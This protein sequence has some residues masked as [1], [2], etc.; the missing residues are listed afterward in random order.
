MCIRTCQACVT[1]APPRPFAQVRIGFQLFPADRSAMWWW[2]TSMDFI[3]CADVV[4]NF[5][6]AYR[7]ADGNLEG[8]PAGGGSTAPALYP[9]QTVAQCRQSRSTVARSTVVASKR[10]RSRLTAANCCCTGI[11][12]LLHRTAPPCAAQTTSRSSSL[13]C[14]PSLPSRPSVLAPCRPLRAH[15]ERVRAGVLPHRPGHLAAARPHG[16]ASAHA[17]WRTHTHAPWRTHTHAPRR[18]HTHAP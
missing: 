14:L 10:A 11:E 1:R 6:T 9:V 3:F 8:T 12:P 7:D 13:P 5:L 18:T 17:P 2:E 4:M 15:R 16:G